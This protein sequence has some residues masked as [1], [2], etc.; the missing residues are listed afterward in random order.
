MVDSP[1]DFGRIA[2]ANALSDVYAMGGTPLFALNIVAWPRDTLS[3]D[4][5][6]EVVRGGNDIA[7]AA[8]VFVLGGHSVDDPEPKFGMVAIGEVHPERIVTNAGAQPGD[9][10]VVTKPLGTGVLATALKRDLLSETEFAPAVASMTTLN[11]GAAR[12]MLEVGVHAATDVTGFGLLGH[13]H[14][15]LAASGAAAELTS[16]AVP[17]LPL[18]REMTERKA[19]S[20]G[21][22]RNAAWVEASVHF[23]DA[24]DPIT[25]VLLADAQTSGGL[26][27]AVGAERAGALVRALERE[28]TPAAA[29]VGRVV[30]GAPGRIDVQ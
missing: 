22:K 17:L 11:A 24:V 4:T 27:L 30:R 25:R 5:L 6:G 16:G 21:T 1:Y 9:V 29:V 20:G 3:F 7:R 10:L 26:L 2:A 12:A 28:R 23:D 19:V 14:S 13:L 18:A 15:L 8:G